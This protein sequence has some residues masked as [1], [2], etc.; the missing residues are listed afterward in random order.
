MIFVILEWITLLCF[1]VILI[2]K[3]IN[4]KSY[5]HWYLYFGIVIGFWVIT[6]FLVTL[7]AEQNIEWNPSVN[8][9]EI[10][11]KWKCNDSILIINSNKTFRFINGQDLTPKVGINLT[12]G[13]WEKAVFNLDLIDKSGTKLTAFRIIKVSNQFRIIIDN[14]SE[15]DLWDG[16]LDFIRLK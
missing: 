5:T 2:H 6:S 7:W 10:I 15:P 14:Y 16:N 8:E 13:F 4:S 1:S 9:T 3:C 11:G 12:Q